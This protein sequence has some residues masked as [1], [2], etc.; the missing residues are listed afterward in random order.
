MAAFKPQHRYLTYDALRAEL[1][2]LSIGGPG[3]KVM[4]TTACPVC[5]P[6]DGVLGLGDLEP[7]PDYRR[8][9]QA[10][11]PAPT[12]ITSRTQVSEAP[13]PAPTPSAGP[14]ASPPA[15]PTSPR[16]SWSRSGQARVRRLQEALVETEFD[17]RE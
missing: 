2:P 16:P 11:L 6:D 4:A 3:H 17:W 9:A 5:S 13:S 12:S 7:L 1:V 8:T 10:Q 14:A 15:G